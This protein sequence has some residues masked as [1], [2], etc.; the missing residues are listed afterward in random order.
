ME[1]LACCLRAVK[2]AQLKDSTKNLVVG[3]GSIGILMGQAIKALGNK[4]YG[5]DLLEDRVNLSE[6]NGFEK[7]FNIKDETTTI[8]E[9]KKVAPLGFDSVF[10]TAGADKALDL[11]IKA[12]RDGGK[13]IVFSSIKN[14]NGF[15]NNDIYYREITVMGS[16]SPSPMDL[17]DSINLIESKKVNVSEL[18]TIYKIENLNEAI[19]DTLSNKIMKAYIQI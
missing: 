12:V 4:S 3:L 6:K 13:I 17:E 14:N 15:Q 2:R 5:C 9:M 11:A 18:S 8:E 19:K 1:P 7:S 16:Y 10:L